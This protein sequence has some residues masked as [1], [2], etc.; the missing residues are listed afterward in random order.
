MEYIL[1]KN[2]IAI[3]HNDK[4][5][6]IQFLKNS[7]LRI[8]EKKVKQDLYEIYEKADK[9]EYQIFNNDNQITI[10]YQNKIILI[11]E[12]LNVSVL[13][14]G[15]N[16][17]TFKFSQDE[18]NYVTSFKI[19]DDSR[20]FGLGDK[21]S[22]LNKR[23]YVYESWATD[24]SWHHD[25]LYETLYKAINSLLI[26]SNN[27]YFGL[28]FPS[29]FRYYYDLAKYDLD[30][31]KVKSKYAYND[32]YLF[33]GDTPKEIISSYSLLLGTP[34]MIRMKMLGNNQSRWSYE[35]EE[36]VLAVY[37]GYKKNNIPL[38]YIH[39]DIHFMDGYRDFTVDKTRFPDLKGLCEKMLEGHVG[40]IC[41][42]DAGIK[43]DENYR[44]YDYCIKNDLAAKNPDGSTFVG[45]V[46]PG[47]S[48]F[49]NYFHPKMKKY[50]KEECARFVDE[51]SLS[52]IWNDM[53]EPVSFKGEL[54]EDLIFDIPGRKLSHL[55]CHNVYAEHMVRPLKDV[56]REKN[57]RP[58]LFTRSGFATTSKYCFTWNGDNY[59]LWHH[60]RY[61]IPQIATLG[62]SNFMFNGVDIGGFGGDCNKQ[63]LI[64][65]VEGNI[66]IPFFR[67][68]STLDTKAQEPYAYDDELMNIYRNYL[69]IR[70]A[71]IPYLYNLA[72]DMNKY[73]EPMLRTMFYN[74]PED[75]NCIDINDQYMVGDS[76]LM[77][78]ILAQDTYKRI[79]Y[80]PKGTWIDY[81]TNKKYKGEKYYMIDMPLDNTGIYIK[82]NSIIPMYEGL[83]YINKKEIDTIIFNLYGKNGKYELYEDDGETLDY[84]KGIYNLYNV[85]FNKQQFALKVKRNK[86]KSTYKK[87]KVIHNGKTY[88]KDFN[89]VDDIIISF[90][91]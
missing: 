89:G 16:I 22:S 36:K 81:F 12:S 83:T 76:I 59:S 33:L 48:I 47:D 1:E 20:I 3:K 51:N 11:D 82:E 29:T 91:G 15:T 5:I 38:D 8:Y 88:I 84:E 85:S 26:Y 25:E 55:E 46:W 57:L 56:F 50:W 49:P 61:S 14:D 77:A 79:V 32:V 80:F 53:N 86:Y 34:Y 39:L 73:G 45:V 58:Y 37:N 62:M 40:A 87:I 23:G 64:R 43:V 6:N 75:I 7:C 66:L 74:Y 28:F 90:E 19:S 78:P 41:I 42:N 18:V 65:W 17:A 71:L 35:N 69:N 31:V 60:L 9:N 67:N 63:L 2:V 21:V 24:H 68:H 52:G 30:E 10:N 72:K 44:V 13:K 27:H 54:P 70:Y 4:Q